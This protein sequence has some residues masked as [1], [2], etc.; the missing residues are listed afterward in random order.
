MGSGFQWYRKA[1]VYNEIA[2]RE[3]GKLYPEKF[4]VNSTEASKKGGG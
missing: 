4:I 1:E 3:G 2:E